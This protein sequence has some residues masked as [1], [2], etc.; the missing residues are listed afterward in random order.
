[1]KK[2]PR[3]FFGGESFWEESAFSALRRKS[4]LLWSN[5][6][7]FEAGFENACAFRRT[8]HSN[9]SAVPSVIHT[10]TCNKRNCLIPFTSIT[11]S[12]ASYLNRKW[13]PCSHQPFLGGRSRVPLVH[14][15]TFISKIFNQ[16]SKDLEEFED[17][18]RKLEKPGS[19][20]TLSALL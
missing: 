16:N 12:P 5:I 10:A 15:L 4:S 13:A 20:A 8:V 1:M 19:K 6:R 2:S 9:W 7:L 18:L 3:S 17:L 14:H 11:K